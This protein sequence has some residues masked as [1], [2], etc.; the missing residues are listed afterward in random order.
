MS[1]EVGPVLTFEDRVRDK[2]KETFANLVTDEELLKIVNRGIEDALFKQR[3]VPRSGYAGGYYD[4]KPSIV[5]ECA[6]KF[7]QERTRAAVDKWLVE[8]PDKIVSALQN[9][10]EAGISNV[11]LAQLD[12][13]FANVVTDLKQQLQYLQQEVQRR[14]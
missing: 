14:A 2:I 12:S 6:E 1:N 9:A 11:I 7:M 8:N 3:Q 10:I 13:R 4:T 5:E